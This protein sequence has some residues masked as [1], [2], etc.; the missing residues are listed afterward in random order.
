M[1][2]SFEAPPLNRLKPLFP[3]LKLSFP[4]HLHLHE[5]S[6][7]ISAQQTFVKV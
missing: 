1:F 4:S 5:I 3:S 7:E 6:P 2:T